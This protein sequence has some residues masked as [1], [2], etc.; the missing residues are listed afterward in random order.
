MTNAFLRRMKDNSSLAVNC[1]PLSLDFFS[2]SLYLSLRV[3][4]PSTCL[5]A[6]LMEKHLPTTTTPLPQH[7]NQRH[8]ETQ[9]FQTTPSLSVPAVKEDGCIVF[10]DTAREEVLSL[11]SAAVTVCAVMH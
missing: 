11:C 10:N 8:S 9:A 1:T 6:C 3:S 4:V 2:L 5:P 7:G